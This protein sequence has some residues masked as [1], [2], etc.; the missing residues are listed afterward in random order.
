MSNKLS[1]PTNVKVP[2]PQPSDRDTQVYRSEVK[3]A[4]NASLA[5]RQHARH[6]YAMT[7]RDHET[8]TVDLVDILRGD[9]GPVPLHNVVEAAQNN[10]RNHRAVVGCEIAKIYY[11]PAQFA[12]QAY[13]DLTSEERQAIDT[14]I[15]Q[16]LVKA[17][18][19]W[20]DNK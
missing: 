8:F 13:N 3:A 5:T 19:V 11:C 9:Y 18:Q 6:D 4:Q 14:L 12:A 17:F 2:F 10:R 1:L 20:K 16:T 7:L 15:D